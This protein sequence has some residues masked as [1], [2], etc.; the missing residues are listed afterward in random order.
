ML[1]S[2]HDVADGGLAVALA[3]CP[4]TMPTAGIGAEIELDD[5][6]ARTLFGEAPSRVI[7]STKAEA[8][9][10]VLARAE[11]AGVPAKRLGTTRGTSLRHHAGKQAVLDVPVEKIRAARDACLAMIV[12]A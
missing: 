8:V 6:T 11:K 10:D 4:A 3:E 9:A 12:G 7:I 1:S 2:A 5:A